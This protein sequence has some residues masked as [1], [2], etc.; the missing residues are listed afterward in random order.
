MSQVVPFFSGRGSGTPIAS[1]ENLVLNNLTS[2]TDGVTVD[3]KPDIYDG[4]TFTQVH[5]QV[6]KDLDSLIIP[7]NHTQAPIA[8]NYF[9]EAKFITWAAARRQPANH[10]RHSGGNPGNERPPELQ[11]GAHSA[12]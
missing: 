7:T 11:G 2:L 6:R 10:I 5:A 8:P 9:F 3:P 1:Q 4:A 12:V